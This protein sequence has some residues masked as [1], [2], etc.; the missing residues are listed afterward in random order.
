MLQTSPTTDGDDTEGVGN[1]KGHGI[2]AMRSRRYRRFFEEHGHVI[3][4]MS[5]RPKTMYGNGLNRMWSRT[6]KEDYWQRELERIGQQEVYNREVYVGD[7]A[8]GDVFGYQD[9]YSEY[10]SI[11]SGIAGEFRSTLNY[12]HLAR[13]FAGDVSLN[14]SFV[15]AD[16]SK[17]IHAVQTNDVLWCMVNHSI[18]ACLYRRWQRRD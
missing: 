12:W 15:T 9:R 13:I 1:L 6:T 16:P 17:R 5:V 11:P 10:R 14:S 8:P 3:S 18:Q 7:S 4:L 2:A